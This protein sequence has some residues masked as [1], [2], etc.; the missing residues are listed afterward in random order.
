[1]I[2]DFAR[3]NFGVGISGRRRHVRLVVH[4]QPTVMRFPI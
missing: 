1:V 4:A 2:V 3:N